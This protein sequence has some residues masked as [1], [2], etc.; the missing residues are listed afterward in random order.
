MLIVIAAF[1]LL[2]L[3]GIN[4]VLIILGSAALGFFAYR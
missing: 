1:A 4:S 3:T 2:T